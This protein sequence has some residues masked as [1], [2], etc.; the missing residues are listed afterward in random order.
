M[1]SINLWDAV[2]CFKDQRYSM[3]SASLG[4][5][6]NHMRPIAR[7]TLFVAVS[8]SD[9]KQSCYIWNAPN[10]AGKPGTVHLHLASL[11]INN[12][13]AANTRATCGVSV[14]PKLTPNRTQ[15]FPVF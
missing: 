13:V 4:G 1:C 5:G 8:L 14:E 7:G 3:S 15:C 6:P 2:S 11:R 10:G 12:L 9:C